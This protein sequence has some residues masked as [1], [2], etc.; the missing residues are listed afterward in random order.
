MKVC[1]A[2][3]STIQTKRKKW[4]K[5][6]VIVRA[7][8]PIIRYHPSTN[9]IPSLK[10]GLECPVDKCPSYCFPRYKLSKL[11]SL[12]RVSYGSF[13]P[14]RNLRFLESLGILGLALFC[15]CCLAP[16]ENGMKNKYYPNLF[17]SSI[18]LLYNATL[19][20]S[21][22]FSEFLNLPWKATF[23]YLFFF[24]IWRLT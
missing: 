11:W 8:T 17:Y 5:K 4:K 20:F 24:P 12:F 10:A 14:T 22:I 23:L 18:L 13:I 2:C 6:D 9:V 1:F 3:V 15:C 19:Y 16:W 21:E 7:P